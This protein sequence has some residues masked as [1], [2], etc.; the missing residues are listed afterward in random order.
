M[1][2]C[3]R[4]R[5]ER[6]I[7]TA[8]RGFTIAELIVALVIAGIVL[9]GVT[10]AL[11]RIGQTREISRTRLAAHQRALDAIEALRRDVIATIRTDDLFFT[12]I[13][14]NSGSQRTRAGTLD[15][16]ELLIFNN[17]LQPVRDIVYN[18]EG[19]EYETQYRVAEDRDGSAL[20]RRRDPVP[21]DNPEGGGVVEPVADKVVGLFIEAYDGDTWRS[22]WDSDDDGIPRALRVSV[23]SSGV[24]SEADPFD[25]P[26]SIVMLRT[27]IPIDRVPAPRD[28]EAEAEA[29]L[30]AAAAATEEA[31]AA[32]GVGATGAASSVQINTDGV[33]QV[34]GGDLRLRRAARESAPGG[35]GASGRSGG[36]FGSGGRGGGGGNGRGGAAGG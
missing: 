29:Q 22:D 3:D 13:V 14:I 12:R 15:R 9:I 35:I 8:R 23:A 17:R 26:E 27:V 7:R 30:A 20:W 32:A 11:G 24:G 33:R 28:F 34:E 10:T 6:P 18:G 16:S 4:R 36:G 21:D 5:A 25:Q 19:S 1:S 2:S 31:G